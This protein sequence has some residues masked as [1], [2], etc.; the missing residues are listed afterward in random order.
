MPFHLVAICPGAPKTG[1]V[2]VRSNGTPARGA[3][4]GGSTA[5]TS[6]GN[7]TI[8]SPFNILRCGKVATR[9][10]ENTGVPFNPTTVEMVNGT[11]VNNVGIQVRALLFFGGNFFD[12]TFHAAIIC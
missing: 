8:T 10:S 11:T 2:I 6:L 4:I 3:P 5:R 1:F 9:G 7:Y 12:E